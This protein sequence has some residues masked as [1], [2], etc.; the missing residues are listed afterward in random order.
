MDQFHFTNGHNERKFGDPLGIVGLELS[1]AELERWP[2]VA[3]F[4]GIKV[5]F[6]GGS[7]GQIH[8]LVVAHQVDRGE[9]PHVLHAGGRLGSVAD[10][11]AEA[12]DAEAALRGD[13]G[14]D[15]AKRID[16]GVDIGNDGDSAS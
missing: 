4:V 13:V 11:V 2:K 3:E 15:R 6:P 5:L 12:E 16:V 10:G 14:Q 1:V 7:R 8:G 9:F